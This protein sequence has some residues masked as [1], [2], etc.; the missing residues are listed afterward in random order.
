[1][2][3]K[4]PLIA[5]ASVMALVATGCSAATT[6]STTEN[7]SVSKTADAAL[8]AMQGKVLSKGPNG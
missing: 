1:M 4:L 6:T 3:T 7:K 5:A 8:A 2:N